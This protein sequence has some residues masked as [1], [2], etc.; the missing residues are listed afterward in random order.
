[1]LTIKEIIRQLADDGSEVYGKVCKVTEVNG[2]VCNCSPIDEDADIIDVRLVA[3]ESTEFFVLVP[4]VDSYVV[5]QFL[6]K[7]TAYISMV[8]KVTEVKYK[9]GESYYSVTDDGFLLQK[10]NDTLKQI[11]TLIIQSQQQIMVMYGNNPDYAKLTQAQ[12]K[13]NNL[14]R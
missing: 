3:D 6:S 2:M 14:L 12:N 8:S 9:I 7:E 10:G 13:T 5:V 11:L 4:A 1:M